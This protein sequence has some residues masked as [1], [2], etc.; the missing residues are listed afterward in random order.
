MVGPRAL[1]KRDDDPDV[2]F[3]ILPLLV[4][5][6]GAIATFGRDRRRLRPN[7][8]VGGVHGLDERQWPGGRLTIG[9][10]VIDIDSLRGRCVMTT[11]DPDSLVQDPEV[12][13]DIVRRF[14]GRL[15]LNA[16]VVHGGTIS[17]GQEVTLIG[18]VEAAVSRVAVSGISR[19]GTGRTG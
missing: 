11:F 8:V 18:P 15:A 13:R 7:I 3:D 2:R 14:G 16:A 1:L 6:D 17:V 9:E 12:L 4:A 5:T 19:T 10:V